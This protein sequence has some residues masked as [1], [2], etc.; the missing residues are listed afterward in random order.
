L[1]PL[2]RHFAAAVRPLMLFSADISIELPFSSRRFHYYA[3]F[4]TP[5]CQLLMMPRF[6]RHIAFDFFRLRFAA[7]SIIFAYAITPFH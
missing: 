3:D 2:R 7:I 6:R 4:S 1:P 5:F